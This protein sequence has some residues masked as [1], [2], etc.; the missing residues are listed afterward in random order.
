[1]ER[2]YGEMIQNIYGRSKEFL[3]EI[4]VKYQ[5]GR[6]SVVKATVYI[7]PVELEHPGGS[8]I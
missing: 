6:T 3:S 4:P 1:L 8:A 5:D 7:N 2:K